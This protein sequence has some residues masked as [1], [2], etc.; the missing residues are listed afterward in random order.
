MTH[1]MRVCIDATPVLF[2]S[3]G[4]KNYVYH[5]IRSLRQRKSGAAITA[6]PWMTDLGPLHHDKSPLSPPGTAARLAML[7]F[8][9]LPGNHLMDCLGRDIDVF[10]TCKLLHPPRKARL[11]ATIQDLTVWLFPGTHT[12]GV[13]EFE[14]AFAARILRRAD[15]LIAASRST[16]DDAARVLGLNPEKIHV[17][18]HG[19]AQHYYDVT[20]EAIA[21]AKDKFELKQAYILYIG[22]IEPRKNLDLLLD[23]YE[24]LSPSLRQNVGLVLAGPRG[25]AAPETLRRLATPA[26]G[27]RYLGYVPE[28]DLPGVL[29]GAEVL[30]YPSLYEGF[31]FPAAQAFAAGV[32]VVCSNVSSLPEISGGAAVLV[33]P[34]SVQS[35]KSALESV[36][37]S[38]SLSARLRE[39]G[40]IRARDFTWDL[41]A[42]RSLQFFESMVSRN[43]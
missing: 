11:T 24:A 14:K 7:H 38:P 10:H 2:R 21:A 20:P 35:I 19:I 13:I 25:W 22:T 31:G 9:N 6:F 26:K 28:E 5:L 32:P 39:A 33:D 37:L 8:L 12:P 40:R 42:E 15:G 27:V 41:C 30:A 36:L 3:A 18:Y 1:A 4:I 29:A 16:R 34:R 23:A 43:V 17:I